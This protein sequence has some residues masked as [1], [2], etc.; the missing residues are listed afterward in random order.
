VLNTY[1]VTHT[2]GALSCVVSA[3]DPLAGI[4]RLGQ[5]CIRVAD[6]TFT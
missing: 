3:D 6:L 1:G 4:I 2:K 5:A